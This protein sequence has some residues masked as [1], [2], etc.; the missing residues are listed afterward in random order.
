LAHSFFIPFCNCR[1]AAQEL[2]A[3]RSVAPQVYESATVYFSDIADFAQLS[4]ESTPLQIVDFLND[5]YILFDDTILRSDVYKVRTTNHSSVLFANDTVDKYVWI[6]SKSWIILN[7][8]K[9]REFIF[10][11]DADLIY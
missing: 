5:L 2:K 7:W 11:F 8:Q 10:R 3:G 1:F 4:S 9:I 6:I